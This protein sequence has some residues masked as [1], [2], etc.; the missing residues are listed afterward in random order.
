MNGLRLPM[1]N[2]IISF[3]VVYTIGRM[4]NYVLCFQWYAERRIGLALD[5][6]RQYYP[7]GQEILLECTIFFRVGGISSPHRLRNRVEASRIVEWLD[8][9]AF[10]F[11][12]DHDNN[13]LVIARTRGEE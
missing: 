8:R 13:L 2:G 3:D 6:H 4:L 11:H 10:D 7:A 9:L 12:K 5:I 1:Q